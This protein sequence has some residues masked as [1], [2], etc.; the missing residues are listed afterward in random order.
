M[1]T[2]LRTRAPAHLPPLIDGNTGTQDTTSQWHPH[3]GDLGRPAP[4]LGPFHQIT[5]SGKL[6]NISPAGQHAW[7]PLP[8]LPLGGG[9]RRAA[10]FTSPSLTSLACQREII[11]LVLRVVV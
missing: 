1:Q 9:P 8:A 4:R 10:F 5:L 11:R 2:A 7:V 6:E 3:K